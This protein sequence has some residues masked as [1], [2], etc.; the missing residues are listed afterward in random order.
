MSVV[1]APIYDSLT[2]VRFAVVPALA[3]RTARGVFW[4]LAPEGAA[5]PLVVVQSQ[6]AGGAGLPRLSS[7]GWSGAIVVKALAATLA[8]AEA[9]LSE[10]APGMDAISPP[11][12]YT[13]GTRYQR[14]IVVPY[15]SGVYQTGHMWLV[16]LE[17]S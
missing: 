14:P 6:D 15:A 4:E 1:V 7:L 13:I 5:M 16:I 17:R 3:A 11:S 10:V 2:L 12:G 9:L 8:A